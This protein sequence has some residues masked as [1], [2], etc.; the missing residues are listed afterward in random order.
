MEAPQS[1]M[2]RPPSRP[3]SLLD[4]DPGP[5]TA[6]AVGLLAA[7]EGGAPMGAA[8]T[9]HARPRRLAGAV[10]LLGAAALA[11]LA[12]HGLAVPGA[13]SAP[14]PEQAGAARCA[15]PACVV[16]DETNPHV[17]NFCKPCRPAPP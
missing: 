7:L 14:A 15:P 3:P 4:P 13:P 5:A 12:G 6:D 11:A 2:Q 1:A 17:W 16:E 9:R 10:L 8:A